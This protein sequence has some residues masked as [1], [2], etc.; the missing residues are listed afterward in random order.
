ML[1]GRVLYFDCVGSFIAPWEDFVLVGFFVELGSN[2]VAVAN[3][4]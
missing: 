3:Y 4:F 2:G 1:V